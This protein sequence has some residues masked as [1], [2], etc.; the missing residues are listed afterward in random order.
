MIAVDDH[1]S[2]FFPEDGIL[3]RFRG[4][5]KP[6]LQ[7]PKLHH[8]TQQRRDDFFARENQHL[9]QRSQPR[10]ER[11]YSANC[12]PEASLAYEV[13]PLDIRNRCPPSSPPVRGLVELFART[14]R[15]LTLGKHHEGV[16][17]GAYRAAETARW[18]DARAVESSPQSRSR[19]A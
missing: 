8:Q 6:R 18:A 10:N 12:G 15:E 2:R 11:T 9:A 3:G 7:A 13:S 4:S 17:D 19:S 5:E 16:A 14:A 1:G